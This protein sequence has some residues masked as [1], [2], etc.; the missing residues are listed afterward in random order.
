MNL[1]RSSIRGRMASDGYVV[2]PEVLSRDELQC[3]R[4]S[5]DGLFAARWVECDCGKVLSDGAGT[6]PELGWLFAHPGIVAA[7]REAIGR[8]EIVFTGNCNLHRNKLGN[9]HKDMGRVHGGYFQDDVHTLDECPIVKVGVYLQDHDRD[10]AGFRVRVGSQR[11]DDLR[12]GDETYAP[13]RAGDIIL[14][15]VRLT[16]AGVLPDPME[17]AIWRVSR[18]LSG[19][20]RESPAG[21]L[22]KEFWWRVTGK[23]ERLSAF[24]TYGPPGALTDEFARNVR[25][26]L[27]DA[28][29]PEQESRLKP[30]LIEA[31]E[32]VGVGVATGA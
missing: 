27:S 19:A 17:R 24:F 22:A 5:L 31:L 25:R 18:L 2:V 26:S 20:R 29:I 6:C 3:L 9:W 4:R 30:G 8:P 15:D 10:G 21:R 16:H 23:P 12:R 14:F 28:G 13:T 1:V 11:V 7:V 32:R